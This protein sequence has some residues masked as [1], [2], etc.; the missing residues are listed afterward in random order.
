[1]P[2]VATMKGKEVACRNA[3]ASTLL[4]STIGL[5][6]IAGKPQASSRAKRKIG[7]GASAATAEKRSHVELYTAGDEEEWDEDAEADP[8]DPEQRGDT[9]RDHER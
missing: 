7:T 4:V 2:V 9:Q 1:M 3:A 5:Y 8:R 6:R